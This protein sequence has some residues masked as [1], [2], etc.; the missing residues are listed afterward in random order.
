MG[1][2]DQALLEYLK[3]TKRFADLV[4]GTMFGGRQ[5]IDPQYLTEIQRK[6]TAASAEFLPKG[7]SK[8]FRAAKR[9]FLSGKGEGYFDAV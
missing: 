3:D 5:I 2:K 1:V 6:K 4:N 8:R 7:S 9:P